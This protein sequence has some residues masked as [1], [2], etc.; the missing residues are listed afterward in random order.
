[1]EPVLHG[2]A[3][4]LLIPQL[5]GL[6]HQGAVGD[7]VDG[8]GPADLLGQDG[9]GQGGGQVEIRDQGQEFPVRVEGEAD[10]YRQAAVH[11]GGGEAAVEGRCQVVRVALHGVGDIQQA[12]GGQL[13]AM[14]QVGAHG[15]GHQQGG[16]GA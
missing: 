1:M 8:V 10:G 14:E 11:H 3:Q 9:A 15:A 7:V 4:Q 16:G 6:Q 2:V 12:L 5:Q 13:A